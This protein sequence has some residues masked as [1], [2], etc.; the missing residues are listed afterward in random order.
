MRDGTDTMRQRGQA[1]AAAAGAASPVTQAIA[2]MAAAA[3]LSSMLHVGVRVIASHGIPSA[4]IVF[5]R[6]FLTILLTAPFVFRP[7]KMAWRTTV[8]QWHVLRGAIGMMSMWGWYYALS[9]MPLGDAATL[10]QTTGL[11]VVLGA[12][13][14]FREQVSIAR[15]LALGTGML[16]ALIVLKPSATGV[17]FAAGCALASSF[18]WAMSL[19]MAKGLSRHDPAIT[20][21]FYQPL[22][23]APWALMFALPTWVTPSLTD[24]GLLVLLS[25]A[26]GVSNFAMVK[27]LS[28]AD[29]SITAPIDYSK[30]LWTSVAGYILFGEMPG[31]STWIGGAL[32]V[33]A[34][35]ILVVS[36]RRR[37]GRA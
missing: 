28:L 19:L 31:V 9:N 21:A 26:A 23:I 22:T 36:E 24:F 13:L 37:D 29:A 12:A 20:I 25:A 10:G 8:P 6:T 3:V 35:L 15:W 33:A 2:Y 30:L 34:L 11:F 4:E 32:I 14:W 27:A 17:S 16:G 5:L 1:L 7:G 18:L